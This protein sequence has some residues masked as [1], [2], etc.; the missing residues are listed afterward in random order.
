MGKLIDAGENCPCCGETVVTF[1]LLTD[2]KMRWACPACSASGFVASPALE[3]QTAEVR[4]HVSVQIAVLP[5]ASG[6]HAGGFLP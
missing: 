1:A 5:Q 4:L 3:S 6:L 2:E